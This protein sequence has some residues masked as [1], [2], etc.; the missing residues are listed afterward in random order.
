MEEEEKNCLII[1]F[2]YEII[3]CNMILLGKEKKEIQ[4]ISFWQI[5]WNATYSNH[6]NQEKD[7]INWILK[8][9]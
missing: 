3:L 2:L 9:F 6:L 5:S 8:I 7:N 1:T 4:K